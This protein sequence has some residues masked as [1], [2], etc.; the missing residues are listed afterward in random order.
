MFKRDSS[1]FRGFVIAGSAAGFT[2]QESVI[3]Q[4]DVYHRL[5]EAAEFFAFAGSFELFA[6]RAL[7][8][9]MTGSGAHEMNVA[10]TRRRWKMTLV[11]GAVG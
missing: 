8:F 6:L 5:A 9:G 3:A 11:I 4:A 7:V 10:W 1:L 2:V